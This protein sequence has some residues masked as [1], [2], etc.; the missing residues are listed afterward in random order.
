MMG[1]FCLASSSDTLFLLLQVQR[2]VGRGCSK[3]VK[4]YLGYAPPLTS[5]WQE[6]DDYQKGLGTAKS[7]S[8]T[9][10]K[11]WG[12]NDLTIPA[13]WQIDEGKLDFSTNS[14]SVVHVQHPDIEKKRNSYE[15]TRYI[16]SRSY[17]RVLVTTDDNKH[18]FDV[19]TVV[20]CCFV[21]P[22]TTTL[23]NCCRP[24]V[25]FL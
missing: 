3:Y 10:G 22:K 18:T 25:V 8:R 1:L 15:Q 17:W 11:V 23:L 20:S 5:K 19:V 21:S 14:S 24:L 13:D 7:S 12:D 16:P 6:D 9:E 2:N 4:G